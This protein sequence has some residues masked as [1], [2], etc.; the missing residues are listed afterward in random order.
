MVTSFL[1]AAFL[2]FFSGLIFLSIRRAGKA[3]RSLPPGPNGLPVIGNV[4]DM[5]S[6]KEWLT[7]AEWGRKWGGI[8]YVSL[9]G[10]PMII[11]N[12]SEIMDEFHKKS[13]I[14]SD[15]PVL[16]MGG[17]LVGYS[18][19]LVLLRYGERFRNYRKFIARFIEPIS[20]HYPIIERESRKFLKRTLRKQ[21]DVLGHLRMLM[22]GIIMQ[23]TYGYEVQ[24][25]DPKG[26]PFIN[27]I[28]HANSNFNKASTP[29]V[30]LVDVF[31]SLRFLPEWLPGMGFKKLARDWK[32]DTDA[33]VQVP[34]EY[35]KSQIRSGSTVRSFVSAGLQQDTKESVDLDFMAS[36]LYGGGS[37]TT[38]SAEYAFILAMVLNPDV[39]KKA[40]AEIDS[41]VGTDRL[42]AL[43]DRETLPYIN[44]VVTEV[45]RWNSV[46]PT[47]VPHVA[48]ED[49]Q[50]NGYFVPKGTII[51]ANLWQMLHNPET[52]PEPFD[53][54]PERYIPAPGKETQPDPRKISFGFGRRVCPGQTLAEASLFAC[55]AMSLAVFDFEKATDENGS[56]IT[57][58]HEN[59]SGTISYPKPFKCVIKPRNPKSVS[60]IQDI[61][62]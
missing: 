43:N 16:R 18:D 10:Q 60:L 52:Y 27:L 24:D 14:Y 22:G 54:D 45:L 21:E 4:A 41:I 58:V 57:P 7:F 28:E 37:D 1:S 17:E 35:T 13:A 5:P 61:E 47:G 6:E 31:P 11:L 50:I 23:L 59:T 8:V 46:A 3:R 53:F 34:Y 32:K 33:M 38:V 56:Q 15:R 42:P 44:A 30:F 49:G 29:G 39:Q 12:D 51:I 25:S 40:Q 26:D 19:T 55:I 48:S 20:Q 9:L 36:S 2:L 62:E